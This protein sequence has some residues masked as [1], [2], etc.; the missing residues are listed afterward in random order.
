MAKSLDPMDPT[1][2]FY[3]AIQKQSV[4]RP[5]EALRDMQKA[6]ELNDNRAV[7]RSRLLLDGDLAARSASLGRIYNDL[8][9]QQVALIEGWKSINYDP[10]NY[11]A[12]RFLADTYSSL[13]RHEIARVSELL[14]SQ[15][16]QPINIT[17][18]QPR[19]AESNLLAASAGGPSDLSF[20]EFNPLFERNRA[21]LQASG[22][23][24][25]DSTS[26]LE[27]VVSGLYN[28]VS[29]SLGVYHF[30]TD[31]FRVNDDVKNTVYNGFVQIA[32]SPKA[33][34]QAEYRHRKFDIGDIELRFFEDFSPNLRQED[35]TDFARLGFH[36]AFSP[37]SDLLVSLMF[38]KEDSVLQDQFPIGIPNSFNVSS[39]QKAGSGELQHLYRSNNINVVSGAGYFDIKGDATSNFQLIDPDAGL[40]VFPPETT[41]LDTRHLNLYVYAYLNYL[42]KVTFTLGASFDKVDSRQSEAFDKNQ[43]NPKLGVTWNPVAD[44]TFRASVF[45][46]LKRTLIT[47]QTLEPTQVAGFNQFYDDVTSTESWNYGAAVDQKFNASLYGGLEYLQRDLQIPTPS[48]GVF[49]TD[50][51]DGKEQ[52]ARAYLHGTPHKWVALTAN[53]MYEKFERDMRSSNA[54]TLETQRVPLGI[55]FSHPSGLSASFKATYYH[56]KGTYLPQG[57]DPLPENLVDGKDSFWLCDAAIGYRLPQRYGMISIGAKNLFDQSFR[58]FDTDPLNPAIQPD[59]IFYAKI[60]LSI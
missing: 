59:R 21:T 24:G 46:A 37:G 33:S 45:R 52:L 56:Q 41:D 26:G 49:A 51:F 6:I 28:N 7:Y 11:S 9:F 30:Q 36:Y 27:G 35:K 48:G 23:V 2:Y 12:H 44:T 31:G 50:N 13:P 20:N 14:Q 42:K 8:G 54:K 60:T 32:L 18:V 5:V 25:S 34:I 55:N 38:Q 40:I 47:N 58:Y 10:A 16:L 4:N 17:P 53:Y 29:L 39:D 3:D 43:F 22:L 1:P 15:L 19:L 57:A